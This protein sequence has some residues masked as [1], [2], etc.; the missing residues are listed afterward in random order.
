[1]WTYPFQHVQRICQ[2][3]WSFG[4]GRKTVVDRHD[5]AAGVLSNSAAEDVLRVKVA[6]NEAAAMS[7]E[8]DGKGSALCCFHWSVDSVANAI[9]IAVFRAYCIGWGWV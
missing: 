8:A 7:V 5:D 2:L 9:D 4:L 3:G 1:M 6:H